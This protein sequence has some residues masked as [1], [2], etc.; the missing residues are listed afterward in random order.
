MIR[1]NELKGKIVACGLT[2]REVAKSLGISER[3]L[4][5]RLKK[6]VFNNNEIETLMKLLGISNP[7]DIFF[8]E[9]VS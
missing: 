3:G 5:Y 9:K 6:G 7:V 8:A 2:Q 4:R 1:I